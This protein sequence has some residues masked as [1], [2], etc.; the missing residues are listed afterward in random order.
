MAASYHR[1]ALPIS[2]LKFRTL[3]LPLELLARNVAVREVK[4]KITA[5]H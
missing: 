2:K 4:D 1:N 5:L 3:V